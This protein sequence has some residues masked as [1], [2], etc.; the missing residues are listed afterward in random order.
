MSETSEGTGWATSLEVAQHVHTVGTKHLEAQL[1][2]ALAADQRAGVVA[3]ILLATA[4][5]VIGAAFATPNA[6]LAFGGFWTG[7]LL[8]FSSALCALSFRPVAFYFP[9]NEPRS[10]IG[11][12]HI[13]LRDSIAN[14]CA[15]IQEMIEDNLTI[16]ANNAALFRAALVCA[17]L[18]PVAGL[19]AR[20]L[21]A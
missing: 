17:V 20:G 11:D 14:E 8:L 3:G 13:D 2:S 18:S 19:I 16:M 10:W 6:P 4:L 12:E 9:G 5:A 21:S 15:Y 7:G 1:Q